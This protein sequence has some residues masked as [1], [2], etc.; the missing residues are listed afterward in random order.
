M[1]VL[2][3]KVYRGMN[4]NLLVSRKLEENATK[5]TGEQSLSNKIMSN[6]IKPI[7]RIQYYLA[8]TGST[9]AKLTYAALSSEIKRTSGAL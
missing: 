6:T 9:S 7:V 4:T 1:L 5:R 2:Q 8:N 3:K